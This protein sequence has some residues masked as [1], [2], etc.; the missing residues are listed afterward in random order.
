MDAGTRPKQTDG[1]DAKTRTALLRFARA[2]RDLPNES[3]KT[4]LFMGLVGELFPDAVAKVAEGI[5]KLVHVESGDGGRARR[6]IDAY[7]GNAIFEFENSLKATG[8]IALGQLREYAAAI[9]SEE[10]LPHRPL[11]CI[12]ADGAVWEVYRPQLRSA[13]AA[14]P[15]PSDI[16][17]EHLH[18]LNLS[19]D[20]VRE[21]WLWLTSVLFGGGGKNP[22]ADRFKNDFGATSPAFADAMAALREVWGIARKLPEPQLAFE[23]WQRYL[24]VTYG[25]LGDNGQRTQLEELFLKHT[26]LATIARFLVWGAL[27]RG[28]FDGTLQD[29][30]RSI[31]AGD[32]FRARNIENLTEDDFFQWVRRREAAQL[33]APVWERLLAQVLT[34][35]LDRLDE[36]VLKGVYQELVD[37]KDRH[38]LG[39]YY[40][41]EWLCE[42]VVRELLPGRGWVSVL[43][44][45]CG[46]GSF[47]R[48]SIAHLLH[49]NRG[50][51]GQLRNVLEHVVG[52]DIHPL[53]VIIA[54]AT[55]VLA[56]SPLVRQAKR[57]VQIPVYLADSLFLPSEVKQTTMWDAPGYEIRFGG[58]RSVSIPGELVKDPDLFDPAIEA[59]TKVATEFA[60]GSKE[61][62]KTLRV[63]LRRSVPSLAERAD[64]DMMVRALW[65]FTS[66]LA[67]LIRRQKNSIWAFIIRNA[68]RPAMLR[69]RFDFVVGNPPWLSY[70]YIADPDYQ[71]EV[72]RRALVEYK[73]APKSQ[74][75]MTQMELATV[76]LVHTLSTFGRPGARLG[77]VMPR[78]VLSADQH[79]SFRDG[80]HAAPIRLDAYWDLFG[81]S[82]LFNVPSCVVL[83]THVAI[84]PKGGG[85]R[86]TSYS[87]LPAVEFEGKLL[88]RDAPL[89]EARPQL[90]ETSR[91]AKLVNLGSRTAYST[92]AKSAA[93]AP[94]SPYAK[95]FRQGATIV[96]RSFYFVR[97]K[98]L[99]GKVDPERVYWA[100]TDPE[101]AESAKPPY[102]DVRL[103]G[104]IEGRFLFT[105]ALS[106]HLLPFALVEPP[107]VFLPIEGT[108]EG[109]RVFT[110]E[111]LRAGGYRE[112]A[113][114]MAEA[115][116]IWAEKRRGKASKQNV[117]QWLDYGH[118]LSDQSLRSRFFVLYNAAGSN[119]SAAAVDCQELPESFV[120]DH[121]TY[122]AACRSREEADYLAA[123]LNAPSLDR[124]I[125]PFQS[126]GLIG[127]R[128]IHKKVL[129]APIPFFESSKPAHAKLARLGA[130]AR[131]QA[132]KVV[133][134][135]ELPA[136]LAR[137]RAL[138]RQATKATVERIDE[139]VKALLSL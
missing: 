107:I 44:P 127:E 90:S 96:P 84:D 25:Q 38:D 80:S 99:A 22:T 4:H 75:L 70:R 74:K 8:E 55:Y 52:I 51:T 133:A 81:V 40:T 21:F 87:I 27:S 103:T 67:D 100:E 124:L 89:S 33:L 53:A 62:D 23:T 12:A 17:L 71:A 15:R 64:F 104:R 109:V 113:K 82:P 31:L 88:V 72:K 132:A 9:W 111:E 7:H 110:A 78:S 129:E 18:T 65:R 86:P 119:L 6:K 122:W 76:F 91:T 92:T 19:D 46:S 121:K 77:F 42:R 108:D 5:E 85:E 73:V 13:S 26:Y 34:Y 57:P 45:T 10:K 105:S 11:V 58:D 24:A 59:A 69:A 29:E 2:V 118:K 61:S 54:R 43:D 47:L 101:Q 36:D 60:A 117:Y 79:A 102:D 115:E 98:D 125:K 30:A 112:S 48:A 106:K 135:G 134:A 39:E 131:A 128:D 95:L 16:E 136:S 37:P 28:Q 50:E 126:M 120:V 32:F 56:V 63:Y 130:E 97:V 3:A 49:A 138:V 94:A 41:P 123:V 1:L 66:E 139:A 83:A 35:S 20:A 93:A 116:R 68:Y 114:W 137:R 14:R